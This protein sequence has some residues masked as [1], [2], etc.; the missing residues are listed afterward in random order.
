MTRRL[1]ILGT[2]GNAHDIL[3]IVEALN[4]NRPTWNLVGF[5]DDVR[6][7]GSR[8]FGVEV[9]GRLGEASKFENCC[10]VNAIGSDLSYRRRP[11][12]IEATGLRREQF[13][14]LVHPAAWVSPRARMG[15]DVCI[16]AG[17]SVAGNATI[18]DHASIGPTCV[19]G[20]DSVIEEYSMLAPGSIVSGFVRV[21]T[22]SYIGAGAMIRQRVQVGSGA[23][24]GLGAV[25]V[26]DVVEDTVVIGNPAKV[27]Q[28]PR[29]HIARAG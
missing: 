1:I 11:L 3:D 4:A 21:G 29:V 14:T 20:H 26:K 16:N 12:I 5:L 2:G 8:F 22:A 23:L 28:R 13:A 9:L 10:F 24:V 7:P 6:E 15:R 19:V 27:L 25:V 17:A 18:G